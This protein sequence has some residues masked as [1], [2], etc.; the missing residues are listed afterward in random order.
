MKTANNSSRLVDL[1]RTAFPQVKC[2]TE[3]FLG[4]VQ[5]VFE[6]ELDQLKRF[7]VGLKGDADL[8]LAALENFSVYQTERVLVFTYFLVRTDSNESI[9]IRTQAEIPA[10]GRWV[11]VPSLVSEWPMINPFEDEASE[12]FGVRF[13]IEGTKTRPASAQL[14][15]AGWKGFPLR[16]NYIFPTEFLG[17]SHVRQKGMSQ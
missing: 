5:G 7:S 15:P 12:L 14:L 10:D 13:L 4:S 9:A 8:K 17:I 2:S 6:I 16:K 3:V 1:V 11:E